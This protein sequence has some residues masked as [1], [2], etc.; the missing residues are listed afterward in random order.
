MPDSLPDRLETLDQSLQVFKPTDRV[1]WTLGRAFNALLEEIKKDHGDD[2]IV[3]VI[4]PVEQ[5]T[6]MGVPAGDDSTMT[7]GTMR[8]AIAQM[9][10]AL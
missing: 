5:G 10:G 4:E 3:S 2:M 6:M 8:A 1:S 7:V 9:T